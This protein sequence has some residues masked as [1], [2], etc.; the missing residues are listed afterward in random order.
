MQGSTGILR[1]IAALRLNYKSDTSYDDV[2]GVAV[3]PIE[4]SVDFIGE[5]GIRFEEDFRPL[6]GTMYF[7]ISTGKKDGLGVDGN[8]LEAFFRALQLGFAVNEGGTDAFKTALDV[9]I[10]DDSDFFV[11]LGIEIAEDVRF[12]VLVVSRTQS[13]S[14]CLYYN[15]SILLIFIHFTVST[16]TLST[17]RTPY[18]EIN[19]LGLSD[20]FQSLVVA[21]RLFLNTK[22]MNRCKS[23]GLE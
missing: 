6:E 12:G 7:P 23:E 14:H 17:S 10:V 8:I 9:V 11:V 16:P 20:L 15:L 13:T 21:D 18:D 3:L 5:S 4:N 19:E 2:V 1:N 22:E